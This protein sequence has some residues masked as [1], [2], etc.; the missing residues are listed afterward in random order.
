MCVHAQTTPLPPP[1]NSHALRMIVFLKLH[2]CNMFLCHSQTLAFI[3]SI[4]VSSQLVPPDMVQIPER[5][6]E[7]E[8]DEPASLQELE[9]RRRAVARIHNILTRSR[10]GYYHG[11]YD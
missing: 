10:L 11:F 9:A 4:L 8:A 1:F 7:S 6:V 2:V 3:K 5:Y